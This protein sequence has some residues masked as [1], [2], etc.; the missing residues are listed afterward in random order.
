MFRGLLAGLASIGVAAFL[1]GCGGGE[2]TTVGTS[3]TPT[4]SIQIERA[5]DGTANAPVTV[6]DPANVVI[7]ASANDLVTLS[8]SVGTLSKTNVTPVNGSATVQLSVSLN[9]IN[10]GTVTATQA[11]GASA[12]ISFTVGATNLNIGR[13]NGTTFEAGQL[14]LGATTLSPGGT[15]QVTA[16]VWNSTLDAAYDQPINVSFSSA[17]ITSGSATV[18][19]PIQAVNGIASTTYK[20][21]NCQGSDTITAS[22]SVGGSQKTASGTVTFAAAT[23]NVSSITFVSTNPNFIN[24]IGVGTAQTEVKFKVLNSIGSP[25]NGVLV[26]FALNTVVGGLALNNSSGTTQADGTVS[27]YVNPG[28]VPTAVRV[29]ATVNGTAISSQSSQLAVTTGIPAQDRIS[30][31]VKTHAVESYEYDGVTVPVTAYVADRFG[32]PAP[33]NT[34]ITFRTEVNG[35]A[36]GATCLTVDGTCGVEWRSQGTRP[37]D[38]RVTILA[39]ALGEETFLD[40]N[41]NG[42]YDSGETITDLS[43]AF[44]D[45]NENGLRSNTEEFVD[46]NSNGIFDGPNGLFSGALCNS[47]CAGNSLHVRASNVIVMSSSTLSLTPSKTTL[48]LPDSGSDFVQFTLTDQY[49][50]PAPAGTT[51][52]CSVAGSGIAAISAPSSYTV[53][54]SATGP[55]TFVCTA[56][57]NLLGC[58]AGT[59]TLNVQTTTPRGLT[60]YFNLVTV[61]NVCP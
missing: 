8:T 19:T 3:T 26:N 7:T 27:T 31:A 21:V 32:N 18:S 59:S 17:C 35:G 54:D 16:V 51:V 38:H 22:I 20:N 4:L 25:V 14:A 53:P 61:N 6:G 42:R 49:G 36:I 13:M 55:Y 30:I 58:T 23:T 28:S 45:A 2:A 11:N 60:Q 10:D 46:F 57:E 39:T 24:L 56:R 5:S 33:D 52:T 9:D 40:A 37:D 12:A 34:A 41:A 50:Q 15:M 44:V 1:G 48:T 29:T 43:E 47:G